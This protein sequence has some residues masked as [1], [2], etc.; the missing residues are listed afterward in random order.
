MSN[1]ELGRAIIFDLFGTLV[2]NFSFRRHE[3]V[4]TRMATLL[5]VPRADFAHTYGKE[6]VREDWS[7]N[8]P[9]WQPT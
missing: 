2:D 1:L 3:Q 9:L 5:G 7:G 4:V 8:S 6:P